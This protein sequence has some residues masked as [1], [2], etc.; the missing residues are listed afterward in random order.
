MFWGIQNFRPA[1]GTKWIPKLTGM[2]EIRNIYP[3]NVRVWAVYIYRG[4]Q[5]ACREIPG[6][7]SRIPRNGRGKLLKEVEGWRE[8]EGKINRQGI[9]FLLK[10]VGSHKCFFFFRNFKWVWPER[11]VHFE[12]PPPPRNVFI[13]WGRR[14]C[15]KIFRSGSVFIKFCWSDPHIINPDPHHLF[16]HFP[17][18]LSHF[19][20]HLRFIFFVLAAIQGCHSRV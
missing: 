13:V 19:Y 14:G 16:F 2:I 12:N 17:L 10:R 18:P 7:N 8:R 15:V 1:R 4:H 6:F 20:P 11:I 9:F 3:C 5:R